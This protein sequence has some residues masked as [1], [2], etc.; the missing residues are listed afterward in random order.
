MEPLTIF[1]FNWK[2]QFVCSFA[3]GTYRNTVNVMLNNWFNWLS[4]QRV[5]C[6]QQE[7]QQAFKRQQEVLL[8]AQKAEEERA[9]SEAALHALQQHN[10]H[11]QQQQQE[12]QRLAGLG[13][14]RQQRLQE[15]QEQQ[16]AQTRHVINIYQLG[17]SHTCSRS[18]VSHW[19]IVFGSVS[20]SRNAPVRWKKY[21]SRMPILEQLSAIIIRFCDN[22][23]VL[24]CE[25]LLLLHLVLASKLTVSCDLLL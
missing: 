6:L 21:V 5:V 9:R 14:D 4:Q 8:R 3:R 15:E 18:A 2:Q 22:K 10:L 17:W 16:E 25:W 23:L 11:L 24:R 7:Q 19:S 12:A 1:W 13:R 20:G